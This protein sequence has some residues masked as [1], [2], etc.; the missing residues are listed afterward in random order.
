MH[1]VTKN[2]IGVVNTSRVRMPWQQAQRLQARVGERPLRGNVSSTRRAKIASKAA[3]KCIVYSSV[4]QGA[5]K[6]VVMSDMA[7]M[8][9][10]A[11]RMQPCSTSPSRTA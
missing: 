8:A 11:P 3:Q 4:P 9:L 5:R 7:R 1:M 6:L 10:A 2:G